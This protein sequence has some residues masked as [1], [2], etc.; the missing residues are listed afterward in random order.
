MQTDQT[1]TLT[2]CE[3]GENH[4]GMQTIGQ[5]AESGFSRRELKKAKQWFEGQGIECELYKLN[6][7]LEEEVKAKRAYLL[8]A[9]SGLDV[10]LDNSAT[11]DDVFNEQNS[12]EKD[13]HAKMYGRVVSKKARHNLCFADF[14]QEPDYENGKGTIVNFSDVPIMDGLRRNLKKPFGEKAENMMCE[15][16]YYYDVKKCY[17]GMHGDTERK[18]IIGVR[19]GAKFPLHYQWYQHSKKIGKALEIKLG[20]GDVYCMSE[21]A[22]GQN[23]KKKL[24]PTLRHAAGL[25]KNVGQ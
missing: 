9:K 23:W 24:I 7:L 5:I 2:F 25:K 8:V 17:I 3:S 14:S 22:V 21:V 1:F 11:K 18:R 13:K 6:D 15:G 20:H 16:N 4:K 10:L 19:L 12:L